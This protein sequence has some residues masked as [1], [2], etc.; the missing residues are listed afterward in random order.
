MSSQPENFDRIQKLLSLKRHEVPP[1]RFFNEFAK[2]VI[3]RLDTPEHEGPSTWWQRLG[4]DFDLKPAMVC[5][6]GM[7]VSALLLFGILASLQLTET[8]AVAFQPGTDPTR[9]PLVLTPPGAQLTV[10]G[11]NNLKPIARPEEIPPS[12]LPIVSASASAS[13]FSQFQWQVQ[14]ASWGGN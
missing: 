8:P 2:G 5:A 1:P 9:E 10:A 14:K 11:L 7:T 6:A 3:A 12:T 13:P 4:L